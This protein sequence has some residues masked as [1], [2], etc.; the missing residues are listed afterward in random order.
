MRLEEVSTGR[1]GEEGTM[2]GR[3]TKRGAQGA[4]TGHCPDCDAE[5][6]SSHVACATCGYSI[7]TQSRFEGRRAPATPLA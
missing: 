4:E 7:V 2:T 1:R 6:G 5:V 3:L